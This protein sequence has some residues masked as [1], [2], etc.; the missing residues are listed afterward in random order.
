MTFPLIHFALRCA[1]DSLCFKPEQRTPLV[2]YA[3]TFANLFISWIVA[4]NVPNIWTPL[5]ITGAVAAGLIGFI[6]PSMLHLNAPEGEKSIGSKSLALLFISLGILVGVDT[7]WM[8]MS[9][10]G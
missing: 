1:V 7:V 5:Q 8:I 9:G 2:R 6:I 4:M 3:V 10:Q